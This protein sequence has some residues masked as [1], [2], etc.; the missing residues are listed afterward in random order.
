MARLRNSRSVSPWGTMLRMMSRRR[1]LSTL[2]N[3]H[4]LQAAE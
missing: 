2:F 4:E 1:S 3:H